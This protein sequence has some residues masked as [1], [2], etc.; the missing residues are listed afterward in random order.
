M[1]A[2]HCKQGLVHVQ[3]MFEALGERG[4]NYQD[5]GVSL[6]R[7]K[8]AG[9]EDSFCAMTSEICFNSFVEPFF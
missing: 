7:V 1:N 5:A 6:I 4:Q 8:F 2:R 9:R 3:S